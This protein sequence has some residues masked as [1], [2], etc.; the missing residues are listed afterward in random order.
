[1]RLCDGVPLGRICSVES[2]GSVD[3][4]GLRYIVFLAGCR[5]RCL[6]CHNPETWG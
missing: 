2:F 5:L 4:P 3:G 6:Y 1:M